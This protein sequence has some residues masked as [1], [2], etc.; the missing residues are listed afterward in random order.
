MI[1]DESHHLCSMVGRPAST[2]ETLWQQY[3]SGLQHCADALLRRE[4]QPRVPWMSDKMWACVQSEQ[5]PCKALKHALSEYERSA[6]QKKY[7]QALNECKTSVK[8]DKR[9]YW[10]DKAVALEADFAAKRG[11][12]AYKSVGL[13]DELDRVQSLSAGKL[14]RSDGSHTANIKEKA[15]I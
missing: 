1:T 11:H 5:D 12:A 8:A 2:P 3:K 13:R 6:C 15:D 4:A 7:R 14:R 10:R 9:A